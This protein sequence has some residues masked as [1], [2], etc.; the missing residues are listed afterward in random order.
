MLFLDAD[1]HPLAPDFLARLLTAF[2]DPRTVAAGGSICS[3]DTGFWGRYQ[4]D[5]QTRRMRQSETL[6]PPLLTTA[7][8]MVRRDAF[9]Q[10]GGFDEAF[11]GYGFEDRDLLLRLAT[12][13]RVI[14]VPGAAVI[15]VD[16]LHLAAVADKMFDAGR[17]TAPRFRALHPA[18]Y[19]ALGY[20]PIDAA[21]HPWLQPVARMLGPLASG[22]APLI[23][24][25][26]EWLPYPVGKLLVKSVSAASFLYGTSRRNDSA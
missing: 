10:C 17:N 8:L 22:L 3:V 6:T 21:L 7:N 23:D 26:L 16:D 14:S 18:A 25:C 15:H 12:I 1:C 2:E 24:R 20:A 5:I 13:G 4:A 11:R 19:R 9:L